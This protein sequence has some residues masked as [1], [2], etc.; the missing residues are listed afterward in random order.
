MFDKIPEADDDENGWF[1][2]SLLEPDADARTD[3]LDL[4]FGLT[5]TSRL[6]CQVKMT[7]DLDGLVVKLPSMTRNMQAAVS[8]MRVPNGAVPDFAAGLR[9]EIVTRDLGTTCTIF[10]SMEHYR[11]QNNAHFPPS[12]LNCDVLHIS[13]RRS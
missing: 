7:K 13:G 1:H 6:G 5:E 10:A 3:M 9:E 11:V 12:T 8:A 4:A 2:W